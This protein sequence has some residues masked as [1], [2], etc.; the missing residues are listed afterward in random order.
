MLTGMKHSVP[1]ALVFM[2]ILLESRAVLA[3]SKWFNLDARPNPFYRQNPNLKG[4]HY[5]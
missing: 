3:S 1:I 4:G 2:P 5:G